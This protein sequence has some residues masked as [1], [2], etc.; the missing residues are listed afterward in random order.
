MVIDRI[1]VPLDVP[2]L[3]VSAHVT[4]PAGDVLSKIS[5][6]VRRKRHRRTAQLARCRGGRRVSSRWRLG[7]TSGRTTTGRR[8]SSLEVTSGQGPIYIP[9]RPSPSLRTRPPVAGLGII[10]AGIGILLE[11]RGM[12]AVLLGLALCLGGVFVVARFE[13]RRRANRSVRGNRDNGPHRH[14]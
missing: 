6:A 5:A 2:T 9:T 1:G 4:A 10:V 12:W 7:P 14:D 13:Y 3:I 11:E 8:D